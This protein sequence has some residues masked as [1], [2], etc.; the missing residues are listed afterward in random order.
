MNHSEIKNQYIKEIR[1]L[2]LSNYR[3]IKS[4]CEASD[5]TY[6]YF[7]KVMNGAATPSYEMLF[8]MFNKFGKT[9]TIAIKEENND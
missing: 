9:V 4:A 3:N 6:S 8:D 1:L 2:M 5:I 7:R